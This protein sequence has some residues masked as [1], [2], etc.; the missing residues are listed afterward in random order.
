MK[1]EVINQQFSVKSPLR[2]DPGAPLK[3]PHSSLGE[4]LPRSLEGGVCVCAKLFVIILVVRF[5]AAMV[6]HT[7]LL[8]GTW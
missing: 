3:L 8:Q 6:Q 5:C 7:P 2:Q 1:Q 4:N